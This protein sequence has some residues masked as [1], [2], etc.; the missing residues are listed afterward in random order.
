MYKPKRGFGVPISEWFRGDLGDFALE[1]LRSSPL[2][3][4]GI[5]STDAVESV[6]RGHRAGETDRSHLIY[7]ML[8]FALWWEH[9][10]K[11]WQ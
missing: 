1:V 5:Y 11:R 9:Y 4:E 7:A 6:I 10:T 8:M 3:D 2:K